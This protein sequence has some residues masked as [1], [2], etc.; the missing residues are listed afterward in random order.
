MDKK[1]ELESKVLGCIKQTCRWEIEG[2][3][4][5][6]RSFDDL[7]FDSLDSVE[8][9]MEIEKEFN[10]DLIPDNLAINFKCGNDIVKYL[11]TVL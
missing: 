4:T 7:L 11:E 1:K 5:L 3:I 8:L 6:D 10:L 9:V 2:E